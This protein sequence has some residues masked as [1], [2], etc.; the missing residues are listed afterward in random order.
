MAFSHGS[1][2]RGVWLLLIHCLS[3]GYD[4][5]PLSDFTEV[6]VSV[7][8]VPEQLRWVLTSVL[9]RYL[10]SFQILS[11]GLSVF[12]L[13]GF[14]IVLN[15]FLFITPFL[16]VLFSS[17]LSTNC[18]S[19]LYDCLFEFHERTLTI[20]G[21]EKIFQFFFSF[22]NFSTKNSP[23]YFIDISS[24]SM[25]ATTPFQAFIILHLNHWPGLLASLPTLVFFLPPGID[26]TMIH[27]TGTLLLLSQFSSM[28]TSVTSYG[29]Q[30]KIV[31]CCTILS[32]A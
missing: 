2:V 25:P 7:Q 16:C 12:L 22:S 8:S 30:H 14:V 3:N 19:R 9:L 24:L 29:L 31:R 13:Y 15:F 28:K 26:I 10:P 21:K 18:F 27:L 4:C 6:W 17:V 11:K 5:H 20:I 23:V 1:I 32:H